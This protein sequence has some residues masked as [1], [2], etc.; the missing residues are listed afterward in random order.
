MMQLQTKA[1]RILTKK[2]AVLRLVPLGI[3]VEDAYIYAECTEEDIEALK[4]DKGFLRDLEI[5]RIIEEKRLLQLHKKAMIIAAEKGNTQGIQWKLSKLKP[6]KWGDGKKIDDGNT[7]PLKISI[8]PFTKEDMVKD[9]DIDLP[10][11]VQ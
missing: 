11:G 8:V 5:Y 9:D 4:I 1:G 6:V 3:D 7:T 2:E 10:N